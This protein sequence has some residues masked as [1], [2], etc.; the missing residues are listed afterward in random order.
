MKLREVRLAL[1]VTRTTWDSSRYYLDSR[2][3]AS[4]NTIN[5]VRGH[6]INRVRGH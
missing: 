2:L 5:R 6:Y 4:P 3:S 1:A